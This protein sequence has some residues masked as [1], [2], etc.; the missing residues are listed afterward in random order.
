MNSVNNLIIVAHMDDEIL[1]MGGTLHKMKRREE[2]TTLV[3]AVNEGENE[4]RA[5]ELQII[6]TE[7]EYKNIYFLGLSNSQLDLVSSS[8][9]IAGVTQIING[10][11]KFTHC[12]TH[13]KHSG[14][15]HHRKIAEVVETSARNML[16]LKTFIVPENRTRSTGFNA[17]SIE[18]LEEEDVEF[19]VMA[20]YVY[21][22]Y[23]DLGLRT[24]EGVRADLEY[25]GLEYGIR[26]AE[27]FEIIRE[28]R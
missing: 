9:L 21:K 7:L 27:K 4:N 5:E 23:K 2:P 14:N 20:G 28:V 25:S 1:G 3:V 18:S 16:N 17:N 6:A 8:E 10:K 12:Y 19:K 22:I 26:Y 15:Q 24:P 13:S 11:E